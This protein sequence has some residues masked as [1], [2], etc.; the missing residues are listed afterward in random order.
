[1]TQA[2]AEVIGDPIAHSKSPLIH[3]FWLEKLGIAADYR[4]TRVA[5]DDLASFFA[6]RADDPAWRGCNVTVP[7]KVAALDHVPDPGGLRASIGAINTVFR[8]EGGALVGTNT[9]AAGF[10]SPIAGLDLAGRPVAVVGAGGAARAVLFALAR[11]GVGRVTLLNRTPLKGAALLAQF[12]L[13]GDALPL[14]ARL[15]AA[16]LLVNTSALGMAGQPPLDLDLSPLPDDAVVYDIVYAPLETP[17]LAAAAARGLDTV[18]GL[19]MLVGQA[20]LA[21]ELFF[22]AAPPRD[23]DEELRERLLA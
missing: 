3:G 2:Y 8:D 14:T 17:L 1:M 23:H 18:D 5:P 16:A 19:E 9:D 22:G 20:A 10:V 13:K 7:H 15:P 6:A 12:G 4:A 11:L 21:F